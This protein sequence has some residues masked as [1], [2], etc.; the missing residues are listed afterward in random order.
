VRRRYWRAAWTFLPYLRHYK[1]LAAGSVGLLVAGALSDL[2]SPWPFALLVG[3]VLVRKPLPE[4]VTLVFGANTETLIVAAV[5]GG[6]LL[7]FIAHG[8]GVLS[9][10]VNTK[11]DLSIAL[12]FRSTLFAHCLELSDC[13]TDEA[14]PG[15]FMY[16]INYEARS[17]GAMAVAIPPLAQSLITLAG[18]FVIALTLDPVLALLAL[19]VV[20]FIY[21]STGYYAKRIEPRL[22][23]VRGLEGI[24]L[25][26]VNTAM[27]MIHVITSFNRQRDEHL[28]FRRQGERARDMRVGLTVRQT[29]FSLVVALITAAGTAAILDVGAHHVLSGRTSIAALLV[30]VAYIASMYKPLEALASTLSQL[31]IL[32]VSIMFSRQLLERKPLVTERPNA[33]RLQRAKGHIRFDGVG[34]DYP[35]R[36]GILQGID[37]E[38]EPGELV[39][40]VG[41][42][43][44]GKSTLLQLLPRFFDPSTGSVEIDGHD[45]REVTLASLRDQIALVRQEPLLFPRSIA[46]NIGYARPGATL[47]EIHAAARAANAHDFIVGLPDGYETVLGERGA[48][49]SGGERQRLALARAFLKDA[50]ILILDEPTS[51]IDSRTEAGILEALERLTRGRTTVIA[52]HRLST[53]R[54]ATR[55]L[56]LDHGRLVENGSPAELLAR[57]GLFATLSG[58]QGFHP[59]PE[60]VISTNG[61]NGHALHE[62]AEESPPDGGRRVLQRNALVQLVDRARVRKGTGAVHFKHR[63]GKGSIFAEKGLLHSAHGDLGAGDELAITAMSWPDEEFTAIVD[64]E[65]RLPRK[66]NITLSYE[67]LLAEAARRQTAAAEPPPHAPAAVIEPPPRPE[68]PIAVGLSILRPATRPSIVLLGSMSAMPVAGVVWQTLQYIVGFQRLG[69]DVYYVE[70]HGRYPRMLNLRPGQDATEPALELISAAMARVNMAGRWCYVA[71]HQGER[72]YGMTEEDLHR[73][74]RDADALINLHGGTVPRPEHTQTGRLVYLETDP[75]VIQAYVAERRQHDIDFLA[76]HDAFFSYGE[77]YGAADCGVPQ[78]ERFHFL[79]TRQPIVLEYWPFARQT[80]RPFTTVGNWNQFQD[81]K[82]G[83]ETYTW[84]KR[85][86]F[87]KFLDLPRLTDATFELALSQCGPQDVALLGSRGWKVSDALDFSYDADAYREYIASSR[88][89]F[90]VAKDQNVRLRSGWFSDRSAT[91]L[92]SG[93]PVVTQDTGFGNILPTGAGLFPFQTMDE[94]VAAI[95]LINSDYERQRKAARRIAEEWFDSDVV[96]G[97][98]LRD[99]GLPVTGRRRVPTVVH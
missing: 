89:E 93:R 29:V 31:Q 70:S 26:M 60:G 27:S 14:A 17:V 59:L 2:A 69:Y 56:V 76:M 71:L 63:T 64:R 75:V 96:L 37:F 49:I 6:F 73:R 88:A 32:C 65:A 52:A 62:T 53:V 94:A 66:R 95:K 81:V 21:Y 84:S 82:V 79:P 87:M 15:D 25:T 40:V 97:R 45:V 43:G 86:E 16:R 80:S 67:E 20:P 12:D 61:S 99:L 78:S 23:T 39:A 77:N 48:R 8:I 3:Y 74:Y 30:L 4:P 35:G 47:D 50:P 34:F 42:T 7:V 5:G 98:L 90:T 41:P 92:A 24:S 18:Y 54:S 91:Y 46:E 36:P 9:N 83:D 68:P 38:V 57:G 85:I 22:V 55:V 13:F 28:R 44:A 72:C 10:W 58:M 19:T 51:S 1:G 33:V 11:L